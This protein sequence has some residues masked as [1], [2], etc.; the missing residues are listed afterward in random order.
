M[1]PPNTQNLA[2]YR[3]VT[4]NEM[5]PL[6]GD[7]DMVTDND[8]ESYDGHVL[9]LD[10][11]FG[12]NMG[13]GPQWVQIDLEQCAPIYAIVVWHYWGATAFHT[14]FR[15]VIVQVSN[16]PDFRRD[17][18]TL[19]NNDHDNS[20][21]MGCGKDKGYAETYEG[22]LIDASGVRARY[23]RL[24]SRGSS[25]DDMNRYVEVA[26]YG[27]GKTKPKPPPKPFVMP[28]LAPARTIYEA[29]ERG[30]AKAVAEFLRK[31]V[32]PDTVNTSERTPLHAASENEKNDV[33]RVLLTNGANPNLQDCLGNTPLHVAVDKKNVSL[34]KTLLEHGA[35]AGIADDYYSTAFHKAV[36]CPAVIRLLLAHGADSNARDKKGRTALYWAAFLGYAQ[37][38]DILL[39][40]EAD[41]NQASLDGESP[42]HCAAEEG[43]TAIVRKLLTA[44]AL[45]NAKTDYGLTPLGR[46]IDEKQR[47]SAEILRQNGGKL[48]RDL[49]SKTLAEAARRGDLTGIR[50]LLAGGAYVDKLDRHKTAPLHWACGMH[51]LEAVR[52]L[53]EAGADPCLKDRHG[54]TPLHLAA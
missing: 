12:G 2:A 23:V 38:V 13:I 52:L 20:S 32:S 37:A 16:D 8:R 25:L 30:D 35:R 7:L 46:A 10:V 14:I 34:V 15:D 26:V 51:Q 11:G 22:K 54:R 29:A 43:H 17:V 33:A 1:V 42:L 4:S 48:G 3:P 21:D 18:H 50:L 47:C 39:S 6:M 5:L 45:V 53:L 31:G 44:G 9:N 28:P 19:F 24:Y 49:P 40:D 36:N 41:V 27:L